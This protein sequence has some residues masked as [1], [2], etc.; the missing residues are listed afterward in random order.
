MP[1]GARGVGD[2]GS[3]AGQGRDWGPP[4]FFLGDREFAVVRFL[5]THDDDDPNMGMSQVLVR[6]GDARLWQPAP[7][8]Y[9]TPTGKF[10]GD[11][12]DGWE[13]AWRWGVYL[14]QLA[15][16]NYTLPRG[17][18]DQVP[19]W[20]Q[21]WEQVQL[22]SRL[23]EMVN[24]SAN[25]GPRNERANLDPDRNGVNPGKDDGVRWLQ[26]GRGFRIWFRGPGFSQSFP[27]SLKAV[28][29]TM[30]D[31]NLLSRNVLISRSP[32]KPGLTIPQP[33]WQMTKIDEDLEQMYPEL[34]FPITE[35]VKEDF[36]RYMHA[37]PPIR[38]YFIQDG[39]K[40]PLFDK[41]KDSEPV[42]SA[43]QAPA[44]PVEP[45]TEP[46][47]LPVMEAPAPVNP[48]P[49]PAEGEGSGLRRFMQ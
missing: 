32:S 6:K 27:K 10:D 38:N 34:D 19:E 4:Q 13:V 41:E 35:E 5:A 29:S 12:P 22:S 47:S 48:T 45:P 25:I 40:W 7:G 42:A 3:A 28:A 15:K 49:P 18:D 43:A 20:A 23:V 11:V 17:D 1:S 14:Y 21:G 39:F 26:R 8:A 24:H 31:G 33:D 2:A 44:A 9:D 46:H 30:P 16:F 37:L 36:N